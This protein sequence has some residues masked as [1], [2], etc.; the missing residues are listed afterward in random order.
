MSVMIITYTN[1]T[2]Y[3]KVPQ[4]S[5]RSHDV[6][7]DKTFCKRSPILVTSPSLKKK[8]RSFEYIITICKKTTTNLVKRCIFKMKILYPHLSTVVVAL[9]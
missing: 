9:T 2:I 8:W 3:Y 7:L 5:K 1:I 4:K 6:P